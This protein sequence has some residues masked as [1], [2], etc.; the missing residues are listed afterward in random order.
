[1][2]GFM[3]RNKFCSTIL[4]NDCG[5]WRMVVALFLIALASPLCCG[6]DDLID[7][8]PVDLVLAHDS[9]WLAT[10]NQTS[11]SVS[12]VGTADGK[13]LDE[14]KVGRRPEGIAL[15][16][17]GRRILVSSSYSGEVTI[18][19]V[20]GGTLNVEATIP[21]GYQ[22]HGIAIAPDGSAA[23]VAL[24][25]ASQVA[26]VDLTEHSVVA[27]IDVGRWPR[28]LATFPGWLSFGCWH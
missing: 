9:S 23:Y 7:R 19:V 20:D 4:R 22:P 10:A 21:V 6:L 16:P 8:S 2:V 18:L 1:M 12:L 15:C 26:V 28:F 3:E 11:D 13:V 14:V 5:V 27:H 17:D 24:T 25:A